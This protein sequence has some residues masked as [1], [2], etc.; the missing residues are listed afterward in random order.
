MSNKKK[1]VGN[2]IGKNDQVIHPFNLNIIQVNDDKEICPTNTYYD[3]K[4]KTLN[5]ITDKCKKISDSDIISFM[6]KPYVYIDH[7]FLVEEVFRIKEVDEIN[8]WIDNNN[9]KPSRY[10]G[11]VINLWIKSNLKDLKKY[12]QLLIEILRK[13]ISNKLFINNKKIS[14]NDF[15][16]KI[17]P[18]FV[19]QWISK[20]DNEYFYF[21]IIDDLEK[22]LSNR[23]E[24]S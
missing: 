2:C 14:K 4:T 3:K 20:V 6:D 7:S 17:L 24:K 1:C 10:I 9:S 15:N 16:E 19:K 12:D 23:Y 11:R 8:K 5:D 22:Y 18:K 21:D 13:F